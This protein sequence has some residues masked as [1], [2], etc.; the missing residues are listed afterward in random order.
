MRTKSEPFLSFSRHAFVGA[1]ES[2]GNRRASMRRLP[3]GLRCKG[4]MSY[5][6]AK[7]FQSAF[8]AS[9]QKHYKKGTYR[10]VD[11][12][13]TVATALRFA[14]TI[15]ITRVANVTGLDTIG[16]PVIMVVRPNSR[17]LSVSQGKSLHLAAA[18]ASGLMESIELFHAENIEIPLRYCAFRELCASA[19]V[20]D[21]SGLPRPSTSI[22]HEDLPL[23]WI[24][25]FDLLA[26]E[27]I[28][29]PYE[30]VHANFRLPMPPGHESFFASS[31]GLASGN[32]LLEAISHG[33]CEVIERDAITLAHVS[34]RPPAR[35][36]LSTIHDTDCQIAI[37]KIRTAGLDVS[38]FDVTSDI[39]IPTFSCIISDADRLG[40]VHQNRSGGFGCHLD[41]DTAVLR[42][43]TEAAQSRL[44][45]IAGS[46]DDM[47]RREYQRGMDP[48]TLASQDARVDYATIP[49]IATDT[50][51]EDIRL[52]LGM[53][54]DAGISCVAAVD[55]S[56]PNLPFSVVRIVVPGLEGLHTL[57]NYLT[58]PRARRVIETAPV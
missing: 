57:P 6:P 56:K 38:V 55:L 33:I 36:D 3:F 16:I 22:F 53:L 29:L 37:E 12:E 31:N 25:G 23:L 52:Q 39:G 44:T 14:G 4:S 34:A 11:A 9:S 10:I 35:L 54:K 21:V 30:T 48:G 51:A 27:S 5:D 50:L 17:S 26:D 41:K 45:I 47:A 7:P 43:L 58:G 1:V 28:W 2:R 13:E 40:V 42:A 18:K 20:V 32:N 46:R 8:N 24:E 49:S 19:N 15:G